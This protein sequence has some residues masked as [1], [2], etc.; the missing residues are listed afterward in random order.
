[1]F[2]THL[3]GIATLTRRFVDAIAGTS[4]CI[5]DT[6]KTLPGY[7]L[8]EKYA[9]R[10]GGG[11]NHRLGLYDGVL[12]KDNHIAA[13]VSPSLPSDRDTGAHPVTDSVSRSLGSDRDTTIA[14]AIRT[15]RERWPGASI[16]VEVDTL[17]Q[18]RDALTGEPDI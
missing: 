12:I 5:L 9:V 11:V 15:A 1:N 3:S 14:N 6:R 16:E 13:I 4:A 8:L 7:R 10:C 2:L 18:L 17:D